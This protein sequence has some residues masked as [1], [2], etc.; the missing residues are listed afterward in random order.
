MM[1]TRG[2][3]FLA[4]RSTVIRKVGQERWD[5]FFSEFEKEGVFAAL[6]V[7][8]T[9]LPMRSFLRLNDAIVDTFYQGDTRAHWEFGAGSAQ[10][11]FENGAL[12]HFFHSENFEG[13]LA[14]APILWSAYYD[15]GELTARWEGQRRLANVRIHKLSAENIHVHF[16]Y[17]VLGYMHRGLE[18]TGARVLRM[19]TLAGFSCG[20]DHVHYLL[21]L[22]PVIGVGGLLRSSP[23][24][25]G[26]VP[27]PKNTHS[28]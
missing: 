9:R 12:Q 23:T 15:E 6:I 7:A 22:V 5:A 25:W 26:F 20:D 10:W 2:A 24:G 11:A 18:L 1:Y 17:N 4:R 19:E 13:F 21:H 16:E 8:D 14:T 3:A 27:F 28:S